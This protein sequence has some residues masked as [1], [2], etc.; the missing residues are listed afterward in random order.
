MLK[1]EQDPEVPIPIGSDATKMTRELSAGTT[2][3]IKDIYGI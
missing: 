1:R 2:K 3:R